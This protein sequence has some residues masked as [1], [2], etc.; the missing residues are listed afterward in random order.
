N[1]HCERCSKGVLN[2]NEAIRLSS[3]LVRVYL[4][5]DC[6]KY[7]IRLYDHVINDLTK[8]LIIDPSCSHAYY[9]GALC[10]IR[11][12]NLSLA[13]KDF[14]IVLC[15]ASTVTNSNTHY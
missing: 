9:N 4:Y 13:F 11:R 3:N 10:Y 5:R 1:A 15:L 12:G 7:S 2:C 8:A 6:L 14:A